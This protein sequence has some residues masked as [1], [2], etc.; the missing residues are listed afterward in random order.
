M[1]LARGD[2]TVIPDGLFFRDTKTEQDTK[3]AF[4]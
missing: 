1:D 2:E 3:F 4:L